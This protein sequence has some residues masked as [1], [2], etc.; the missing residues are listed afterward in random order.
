MADGQDNAANAMYAVEQR[1]PAAAQQAAS[2]R[3]G[4]EQRDESG[5]TPFLKALASG[6]F[7][8]AEILLDHGA[9]PWAVDEF[10][11]TAGHRLAANP[12]GP[13]TIEGDAKQR[14]TAKLSAR[15]FPLPPPPQEEVLA[16]AASGRWPPREGAR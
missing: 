16:M 13:G 10:G 2:A 1:D 11:L 3:R 5:N 15:G 8:I 12:W 9:D 14:V 6:Q 7:I 4:L